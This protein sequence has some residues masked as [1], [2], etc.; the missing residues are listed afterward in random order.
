VRKKVEL[1]KGYSEG[2][3]TIARCSKRACKGKREIKK[4]NGNI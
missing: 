4:K 2:N 3:L 1:L